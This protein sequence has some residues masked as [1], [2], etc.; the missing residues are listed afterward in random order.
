VGDE[1]IRAAVPDLD[2]F[3]DEIVRPSACMATVRTG[4]EDLVFP[5]CHGGDL[6]VTRGNSA[7]LGFEH[8]RRVWGARVPGAPTRRTPCQGN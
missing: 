6:S 8:R 3:V 5:V 4:L 7:D 1:R 2:R